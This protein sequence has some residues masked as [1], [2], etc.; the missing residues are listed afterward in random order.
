MP[1][2]THTHIPRAELVQGEGSIIQLEV[3]HCLDERKADALLFGVKAESKH[4]VV[5]CKVGDS[6]LVVKDV[7]EVESEHDIEPRK[8]GGLRQAPHEYHLDTGA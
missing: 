8:T 1:P 7:V 2:H 5:Q 3:I 4:D 6:A